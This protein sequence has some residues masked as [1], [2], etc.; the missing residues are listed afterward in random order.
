MHPTGWEIFLKSFLVKKFADRRDR[1]EKL[2][3]EPK[4]QPD[5]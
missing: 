5:R 1:R 2:S 3:Q 4:N